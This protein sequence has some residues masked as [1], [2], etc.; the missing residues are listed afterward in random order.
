MVP[1]EEIIFPAQRY[2]TYLILRKIVV[3]Q[4]PSVLQISHHIVPAGIGIGDG[5]ADL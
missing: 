4:Q 5:L 3:R 1:A 2:G